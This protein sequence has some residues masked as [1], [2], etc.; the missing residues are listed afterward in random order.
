MHALGEEQA[1]IVGHDWG[2]HVAWNCA[3]LRPDLFRAVVLLSVPYV[4]RSWEDIRP[5]EAM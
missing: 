3:L 4:Q 5:T 1:V 2:A